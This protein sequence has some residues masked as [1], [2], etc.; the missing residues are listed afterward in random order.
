VAALYNNHRKDDE[1]TRDTIKNGLMAAK[2]P[3]F[4]DVKRQ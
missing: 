1:L 2:W 4:K 3:E